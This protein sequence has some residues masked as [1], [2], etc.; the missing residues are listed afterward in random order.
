MALRDQVIMNGTVIHVSSDAGFLRLIDNYFQVTGET[1]D[2]HGTPAMIY[3]MLAEI[4]L[5]D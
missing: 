1:D 4:V 5:T 2:N 3:G